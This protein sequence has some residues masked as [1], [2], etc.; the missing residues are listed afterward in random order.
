MDI[1]ETIIE[2]LINANLKKLGDLA[3][4]KRRIAKKFKTPCPSNISLLKTYH[5]LIKNKNISRSGIIEHILRKR[6]V[7]SLSGI[8]NISVLTKP[9]PCPGKC[10]YCPTEKNIP[11]SYVSGEPAV[12][13]AKKLNFDPYLQ[14]EKRIEMLENE[15]HPTDKLEVRIIGATWSYYQKSYQNWFIK[16]CFQASNGKKSKSKNQKIEDVQRLNE[17][18][19]H[20][21]VGLSIETRPDFIDEKEIKRLRTL[22]IT[23]VEIGVQSIFDDVLALNKRG[24]GSE[25]IIKA[26]KLLKDAGFKVC[27]QMMPDLPGSTLEKDE[28]MF[29]QLF[30]NQ[31]FQPDLLKIYPT[32]ILK[33]AELYKWWK[34]KKYKPYSAKDL[35]KLVTEI[36][37]EVPFYVRIQRITRDIPS[38]D[39]VAGPAKISNLRQIVVEEMEKKG[40]KCKCIRCR[41]IGKDY[42]AKEKILLFREDYNASGGKEIFL[43][44]E[45]E[46]REKLYSL[47]RLRIPA[48][49]NYSIVRELHTYGQQLPISGKSDKGGWASFA[50]NSAQHKGLGKKLVKEAERIAGKEFHSERISI[51]SAVGARPYYRN[52]G[53]RLTSTYM[54]KKL[55]SNVSSK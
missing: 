13:R 32:A 12:E 52:L 14:I 53:Y 40:E 22:G 38:K 3:V 27:Y 10:I 9:Y 37:K 1:N 11:K 28:E 29:R 39:I 46:K 43:S 50:S 54:I 34:D 4:I 30:N 41:E 8:V 23:M 35:I 36:K 44:F 20:R 21:I 24:H 17:K 5:E 2:E 33:G 15:G 7:R 49:G 6:P 25:A 19:K 48:E 18:A 51:I 31:N 55:R 47:L 45:N 16:R 42:D 26:T